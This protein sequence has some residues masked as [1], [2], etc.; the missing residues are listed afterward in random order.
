MNI[1]SLTTH[2][3]DPLARVPV[4]PTRILWQ[5][6][7]IENAGVLLT[8][9]MGQALVDPGAVCTLRQGASLLL[10]SDIMGQRERGYGAMVVS[11]IGI[12]GKQTATTVTWR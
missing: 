8:N 10:V 3:P 9:A 1:N 7:A 6:G 2:A 5:G 11:G 4:L 12:L